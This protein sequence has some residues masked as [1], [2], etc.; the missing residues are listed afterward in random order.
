M[1]DYP[2]VF[3]AAKCA[4]KDWQED[5]ETDGSKGGYVAIVGNYDSAEEC[6]L[7]V[8]LE[9]LDAL[10]ATW[11]TESAYTCEAIYGTKTLRD[12]ILPS[13]HHVKSCIFEGNCNIIKQLLKLLYIL[14][15]SS[16]KYDI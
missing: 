10:G 11:W 13:T 2:F 15:V 6:A 12:V 7:R 4:G 9:H 3:S 5:R 8:Y 16:I 14:M 1:Q